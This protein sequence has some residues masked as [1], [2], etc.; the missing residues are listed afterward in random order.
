MVGV[1]V[2]AL[3][4]L[5]GLVACGTDPVSTS[6]TGTSP[7]T[8]SALSAPPTASTTVRAT[9]APGAIDSNVPATTSTP[10]MA[11][12]FDGLDGLV[13]VD[14]PH[15]ADFPRGDDTITAWSTT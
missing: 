14:E 10:S 11:F 7:A 4:T 5:L 1:R 8:D 12:T 9:S 15:P 2:L 13:P 3:A 6:G